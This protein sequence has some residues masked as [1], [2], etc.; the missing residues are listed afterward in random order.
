MLGEDLHHRL[1]PVLQE[2]QRAG[3][4]DQRPELLEWVRRLLEEGIGEVVGLVGPSA[5]PVEQPKVQQAA[6]QGAAELPCGALFQQ[7]DVGKDR[8][9][10]AIHGDVELIQ[11]V[12]GGTEGQPGQ[13]LLQGR[14][15]PPGREEDQVALL[16]ADTGVNVKVGTF[17]DL[18]Q[19]DRQHRVWPP[20]QMGACPGRGRTAPR[21][22]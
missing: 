4:G 16:I 6:E 21:G 17:L 18:V 3:F 1:P 2:R 15:A 10:P 20:L 12:L 9:T 11:A 7:I 5:A 8:K 14:V 13:E 19:R 22:G